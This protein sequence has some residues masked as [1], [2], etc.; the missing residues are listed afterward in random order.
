[1]TLYDTVRNCYD[2]I[3]LYHSIFNVETADALLLMLY[4]GVSI[5][6]DNFQHIYLK[7]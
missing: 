2:G 3:V 1:M 6:L 4:F 5:T 7:T